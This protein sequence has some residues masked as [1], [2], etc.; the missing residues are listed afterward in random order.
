MPKAERAG[1]PTHWTTFGQG[2]RNALMIHC[3]LAHSAIWGKLSQSLSGLLSMTAF[4]MPGH[5]RSAAWD[6][7]DEI[8]KA[9]ARI[10]ET[11]LSAPTDVIGHSFGATVALRLAVMRPDLVRTLTLIEPVF[12]AVAWQDRPDTKDAF[13]IAQGEVAPAMARGDV[14]TAARD[15]TRMWGD[16]TAW[17]ALP[18]RTRQSLADQMYLIAATHD[19]LHDDVGGM[20][21]RGVLDRVDMPVLL[22]EGSASPDIVAVIN[23]GL[24]KRLPKATR[25]MIMGGAHMS[26]VTHSDQVAAEISRFIQSTA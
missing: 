23:E 14:L 24:A 9:T 25:A 22:I 18:D 12:F 4:D 15:F 21:E 8:Q 17:D 7:R 5:G 2:G 20:L 3:S 1:F 11:F 16:G 6:H 19:A 10:A 13:D 26:P